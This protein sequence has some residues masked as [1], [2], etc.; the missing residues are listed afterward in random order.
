VKG[1]K[2]GGSDA[3]PLSGPR[4]ARVA[5]LDGLRGLAA[6]SVVLAHAVAALSKPI[7]T[8]V[9]LHHSPFVLFVNP[10]GGIHLFF[11]LSGYCLSNAALRAR[12]P[13]GL[14]RFYLRRVLRIYVPYAI[15][16]LLVWTLSGTVYQRTNPDGVWSAQMMAM[17]GIHLPLRGLFLSLLFPGDAFGQI[18]VGW[19]LRAEMIYSF[20]LPLMMLIATRLHWSVLLVVAA[21][22]V[23][24]VPGEG[25]FAHFGLDFSLGLAIWV[26]RERLERLAL[27]LRGVA[28]L[29]V[30]LGG[31]LVLSSPRFFMLDAAT[32]KLSIVLYASGASVLV[33]GA[34]HSRAFSRILSLPLLTW[35]GQ[36]SYSLYLIHLPVIILLTHFVSG[37]LGAVG[38]TA[39]VMAALVLSYLIAPLFHRAV[40]APSIA[41]GYRASAA[42]G[43]PRDSAQA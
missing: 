27:R 28:M 30:L 2:I 24:F 37:R 23:A 25:S 43:S 6:S 22:G 7:A 5:S 14:S 1:Q 12:D 21:L 42:L 13:R 39:F 15:A 35:M 34:I 20:L 38:G 8:I 29:A 41:W 26:E 40:E 18:P 17:K 36:V 3:A 16:L 33:A 10:G 9:A 11:V 4:S 19:T 32:P 31:W